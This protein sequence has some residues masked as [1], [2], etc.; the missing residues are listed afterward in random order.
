MAIDMANITTRPVLDVF[1][2]FVNGQKSTTSFSHIAKFGIL[3]ART[4]ADVAKHQGISYFVCPM[5]A[6]G[7]EVRPIVEMTGAHLFNEVFFDDV[8]IPASNL[9]G[10]E[11]RG[12]ELAKVTLSNERVSLSSGGALWGN[13][14]A[15]RDLFAL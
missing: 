7:I 12:W 15:A 8:R 11:H 5:D 3:I 1:V 13:G 6:A 4:N 14:P 9:V 2:Y 10:E